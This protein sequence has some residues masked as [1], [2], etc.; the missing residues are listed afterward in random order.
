MNTLDQISFIFKD[1]IEQGLIWSLLAIGVFISYKILDFA[2]LT[3]EGSMTLG[4]VIAAVV[5]INVNNVFLAIVLATIAGFIAGTITGILHTKLKIPSI[6][7]GIIMLTALYSI[8]LMILQKAS[9]SLFNN[10]T[11][12]SYLRNIINNPF[13]AKTITSFV[14]VLVVATGI[15]FL[16]GTEI[17][18]GIRATGMNQKMAKVQ[19]INTDRVIIFGL[20]L[21]NA[22]IALG[23]SLLVQSD[24][25]AN[26]EFGRGTIVI[27]LASIIIG[28][29]IFGKRSFKNSLL[30][31]ILGSI[32][33]QI[34]RKIAI[35][36][37][38]NHEA[39][40]LIEAILI[41][42]ILGMPIIKK[43]LKRKEK[44]ANVTIS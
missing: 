32:V 27:G 17:G 4:G 43:A 11:L 10:T 41:A 26:L 40:K 19:G 21:A 33:F 25:Q 31:V 8:N 29:T 39:L 30:S 18:I 5:I 1:G 12:Y 36:V 23:G 20:G 37:G 22:I 3:T 44:I 7:S 9:V 24:R 15:Y 28:E 14:I 13:L 6:L 38:I 16:F 42:V 2:D 35:E 34:L